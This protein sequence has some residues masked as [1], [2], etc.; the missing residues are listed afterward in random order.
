MCFVASV[1]IGLCGELFEETMGSL[2]CEFCGVKAQKQHL[3]I[4]EFSEYNAF[5]SKSEV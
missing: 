4:E 5:I 3:Y 1:V 2:A